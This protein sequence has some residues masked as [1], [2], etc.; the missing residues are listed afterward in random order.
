[1]NRNDKQSS[2]IG[3]RRAHVTCDGVERIEIQHAWSGFNMLQNASLA[4]GEDRHLLKK[5]KV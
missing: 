2:S 3:D 1:M 5:Y 4:A